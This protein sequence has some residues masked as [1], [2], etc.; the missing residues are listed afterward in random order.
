MWA[1]VLGWQGYSWICWDSQILHTIFLTMI[2]LGL[3][4]NEKLKLKHCTKQML[5]KRSLNH[6][7]TKFSNRQTC[8]IEFQTYGIKT[9]PLVSRS[10]EPSQKQSKG[11]M[12]VHGNN[13]SRICKERCG[14]HKIGSFFI[15]QGGLSLVFGDVG[16]RKKQ[17]LNGGRPQI[18]E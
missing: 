4:A 14:N 7:D 2:F 15:I 12:M 1:Q 9:G 5:M 3:I 11:V 6:F 18:A 13:L 10:L 8:G 16:K 17:L